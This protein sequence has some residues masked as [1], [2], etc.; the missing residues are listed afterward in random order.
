MLNDDSSLA[1]DT[2][3]FETLQIFGCCIA[4]PRI[5]HLSPEGRI[6]MAEKNR[7][8]SQVVDSIGLGA[9]LSLAARPA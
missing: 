8:D 2:S 4:D 5:R 6:A 3:S 9:R 7:F 1:Q